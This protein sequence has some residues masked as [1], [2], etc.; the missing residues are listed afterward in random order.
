VAGYNVYRSTVK[1]RDYVKINAT[2]VRNRLSYKDEEVDS[3]KTYYY[4]TRSVDAKGKESSDS[5]EVVVTV[6]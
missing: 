2:L 1:G 3:G 5:P 4:V 6:P